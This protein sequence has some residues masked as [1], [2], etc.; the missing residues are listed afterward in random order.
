M[1]DEELVDFLSYPRHEIM[2]NEEVAR[3]FLN[4]SLASI[5]KDSGDE[6]IAPI[7]LA[8]ARPPTY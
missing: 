8:P 2:I 1:K 5:Q 7:L 4:A 3:D 6:I